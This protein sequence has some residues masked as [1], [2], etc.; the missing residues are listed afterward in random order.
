M[1]GNGSYIKSMNGI[2][3]FDTGGT[4]IEGGN[5]TADTVDCDTINA[6]TANIS[7]TLNTSTIYTDFI[8]NNANP[9]ISI[10]GDTKFNNDLYVDNIYS[11]TTGQVNINNDTVINAS[12]IPNSLYTNDIYSNTTGRVDINNNTIVYGSL[13]PYSLK[14]E[15]IDGSDT[16]SL[17]KQLKIG[18]SNLSTTSVNIGRAELTILGTVYPAIPPRTTFYAV[19]DDDIANKK[20]VDDVVAVNTVTL[21]SNNT[22]TGDNNFQSGVIT[23]PTQATGSISFDA[24]NCYFVTRTVGALLNDTNTW[25]GTSNTFDNILRVGND[26]ALPPEYQ[27]TLSSNSTSSNIFST[28]VTDTVNLFNNITTGTVKMCN[29]LILSRRSIASSAITDTISL[30]NNIT[31][32]TV[33]MCSNLILSAGSIASTA[34]TDAIS[35]FK[36]ITTGS[37]TMATNLVFKQNNIQ[38]TGAADDIDLFT[39]IT[40]GDIFLMRNATNGAVTI[41][42]AGATTGN[43]GGVNIGTGR[44]NNVFIGSSFNSSTANNN[45]CCYIN[46]LQVGDSPALREIRF[47]T[48]PTGSTTGTIT[49]SPAFPSGIT[50]FVMTGGV[51]SSNAGQVFSVQTSSIT[52]VSFTYTKVYIAF[53]SGSTTITGTGGATTEAFSWIAFSS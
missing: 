13:T 47:A 36:N 49:F 17:T 37:I 1:S 29:S 33:N 15:T 45:G 18:Y 4:T 22:W 38:S 27:I 31:T 39:N 28:N 11:N 23:V 32:G 7:S 24:A 34:A 6:V 2:V 41:G 21:T 8:L 12:L 51:I 52:N 14:T 19:G 42:N 25:A 20:Y 44:R 48:S 26:T 30:F 46:K 3:S 40:T 35:L 9:S 16:S 50:P 43:G 10:I 5:I 53:A